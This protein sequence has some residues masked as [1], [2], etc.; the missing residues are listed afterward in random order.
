VAAYRPEILHAF[1]AGRAG[2]VGLRLASRL[3]LPLVVTL[4]GT[5]ANHDLPDIARGVAVRAVLEAAA[6]ITAFHE[7]IVGRVLEI[8]PSVRGQLV[9]VPQSVRL[10]GRTPFD[11]AERWAV[12]A[13]RI[14][15]V[16]AAG[17]RAVK[18]LRR[19]LAAL[20]AVARAADPRV[21]LLYA[22]PILEPAEVRPCQRPWGDARGP[23][24]SVRCRLRRWP[25]CWRRATSS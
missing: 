14:L 17:I 18:A 2:P 5:D 9:V 3:A 16:L 7:S 8:A 1:H 19:P 12:P 23:G 15:F 25:R 22:G 24:T 6:T 11:L 20:D 10:D 4:T 21:R 13:E